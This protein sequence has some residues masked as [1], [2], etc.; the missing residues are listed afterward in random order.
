MEY[1]NR[2]GN[3]WF[4]KW[5]FLLWLL[6]AAMGLYFFQTL[7]HE[8]SHAV[9]AAVTTGNSP[10]L[11]PFPHEA[12]GG[13]FLNGVTFFNGNP[14]VTHNIRL[15]CDSDATTNVQDAG[16]I[17][18]PQ[19][20]DL[21]IITA[22]F[23]VFF[24]TTVSNP[25]FRF[26]LV[27]WYLGASF[28][29]IY[30]TVRSLGGGCNASA[31][32]SRVMLTGDIDNGLFAFLTWTLWIIFVLSHFVW[33]Y[34][35][36]WG[37]TPV[38]SAEFWDYRWIG[39]TMGLLSLICFIWSLAVNDPRI[40]KDSTPFILFFILHIVFAAGNFLLFGLSFKYKP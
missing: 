10:T 5:I 18:L 11:A 37:Q 25:F 29:F 12:R 22:L 23:F 32:W 39:F 4:P 36:K 30:N 1:F 31:D 8:G 3:F 7:I 35:S 38:T 24:F 16:F 28:D 14:A 17:G 20:V 15:S 9:A 26:L 6:L 21:V 19:V 34:F 2:L 40:I 13:G 33:V 27:L